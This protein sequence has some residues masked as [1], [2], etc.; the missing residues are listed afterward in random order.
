M[1]GVLMGRVGGRGLQLSATRIAEG[2]FGDSVAANTLLL[3]YAWQ[4]G[5]VPLSEAALLGAITANG[6]AVEL[7]QRAFQWGRMAAVDLA[8]VLKM[9][10][11]AGEARVPDAIAERLDDLIA[12]RIDDL[13]RYQD[14]AYGLRYRELMVRVTAASKAFGPA[15]ERFAKAVAI[16]AYKLM[17]YK[18]EYEIARLYVDPEF[19]RALGA[20]F[21]GFGKLS[22]WLAPP[23][24]ARPDPVTGRPAK[25]KFGPWIFPV[26]RAL[27]AMKRLRGTWADPF[28][29]TEERKAERALVAEYCETTERIC[30]ELP[31]LDLAVATQIAAL[32][33]QV[34]GYGP[35]KAAALDAYRKDREA[36]MDKLA[37]RVLEVA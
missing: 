37:R 8:A 32:P 23:L 6:A 17:A 14:R 36:L 7:N 22:V 24:L 13:T 9:A 21:A 16:N 5:L 29:H 15:G 33:D 4:R 31:S 20:Q 28:G 25:R 11:V 1:L 12:R 35:V 18:D 19:Q 30:A 34:R 2:L 27:A 10:G 26:L 3:G